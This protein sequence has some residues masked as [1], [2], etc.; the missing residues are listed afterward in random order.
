MFVILLLSDL[1]SD[2]DRYARYCCVALFCTGIKS[3]VDELIKYLIDAADRGSLFVFASDFNS[4][5]K[6]KI[7]NNLC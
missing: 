5:L 6:R 3:D 1:N 2:I 4:V 7:K